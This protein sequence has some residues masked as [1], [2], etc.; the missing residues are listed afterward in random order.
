MVDFSDTCT[1]T[2]KSGHRDIHI[3]EKMLEVGIN[4]VLLNLSVY[5]QN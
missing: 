4:C 3:T 1:S 2:T 5:G